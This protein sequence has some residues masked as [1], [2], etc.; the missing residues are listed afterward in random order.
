MA[1]GL[2]WKKLTSLIMV[3]TIRD[4]RGF[5][6]IDTR[7]YISSCAPLAAPLLNA[8]RKHW[9]IENSL[10]RVLAY[11]HTSFSKVNLTIN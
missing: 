7:F 4:G 9:A 8:N 11:T 10:H 2:K 3:E 1:E 6:T 5:R